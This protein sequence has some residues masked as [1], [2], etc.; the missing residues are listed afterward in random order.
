MLEGVISMDD[1]K[2]ANMDLC[3]SLE[4]MGSRYVSRRPCNRAKDKRIIAR[5]ARRKLRVS[6][7]ARYTISTS[8]KT[9]ALQAMKATNYLL[10]LWDLDQYLR[11]QVKY[12]YDMPEDEREAYQKARD[13]LHDILAGYGINLDELE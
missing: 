2:K 13:E 12:A 10:A 1:F 3:T 11:G 5:Y 9:E 7:M 8:D 6:C 4:V